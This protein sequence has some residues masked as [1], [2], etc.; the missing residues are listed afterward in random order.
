M[1]NTTTILTVAAGSL[2]TI[3]SQVSAFVKN[4]RRAEARALDFIQN[5]EGQ[6]NAIMDTL[7]DL[8]VQLRT[9]QSLST[10]SAST[11]GEVVSST[12]SKAKKSQPKKV[13]KP[14]KPAKGGKNKGRRSM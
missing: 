12:P 6:F 3:A 11:L 1:S 10:P 14:S 2:A 7:D 13:T 4:A 8:T 9:L 5:S